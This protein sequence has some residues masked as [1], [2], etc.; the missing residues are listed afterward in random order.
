MLKPIT[1][2]FFE[3]DHHN[4]AEGKYYNDAMW[5]FTEEQW[6]AKVRETAEI[7][8]DTLV[9]MASALYF[10]SYFPFDEFPYAKHLA[11]ENV[12]D[13]LLDEADKTG[14]KI[15]LSAGF[16]G[17]WVQPDKNTTD[18]EIINRSLKAMNVMSEKYGHHKC[19]EG[20]YMP[21][22]W[23]IMGHFDDRFIKYINTISAEARRLNPKN[24]T[25]IGPYGTR[26]T[27]PDDKYVKQL[28]SLDLDIIAYQ[29][30][31]GVQKTL[32]EQEGA[33]YEALYKAHEKAGRAKIWADM[34]V[35]E[36]EGTVYQSALLPAPWERIKAQMEAISP[37]VEKIIVY[38]YQGMMTKPG[39]I[40]RC[41]YPER[42]EQLY[43]DYV[44][45]LATQK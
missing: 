4:R 17:D 36:F 23:E 33:Y 39:G 14:Q 18:K 35:F 10:E 6:R 8:M 22:E 1:G 5:S 13:V 11:C 43:T 25:I 12:M 20:W 28:E 29:D 21:D 42:A 26:I 37:F 41:G 45:W 15:F 38:A 34:E 3:F 24:K 32:V 7:G 19:I 44:N 2:T 27:T 40:A 16:Y 9:L 31:V 30:E